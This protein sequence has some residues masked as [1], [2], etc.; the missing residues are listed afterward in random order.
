MPVAH[1]LQEHPDQLAGS[2][3]QGHEGMA[4]RIDITTTA[5]HNG[6]LA[7]SSFGPCSRGCPADVIM[8]ACGLCPLVGPSSCFRE[9]KHCWPCSSA[10]RAFLAP[11]STRAEHLERSQ[12]CSSQQREPPCTS[13]VEVLQVQWQHAYNEQG[14]SI[15][16][17]VSKTIVCM[18]AGL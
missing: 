18:L 14:R 13:N 16:Q 12:E 5:P 2:P 1:S 4:I 17:R 8:P 11:F 10:S 3:G 6:I 15:Y 9:G 7:S